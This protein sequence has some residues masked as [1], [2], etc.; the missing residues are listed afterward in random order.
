MRPLLVPVLAL[1][2]AG[3]AHAAIRVSAEQPVASPV[4]APQEPVLYPHTIAS[5][6]QQFLVLWGSGDGAYEGNVGL[7][8]ALV[9]ADG[10]RLLSRFIPGTQNAKNGVIAA[11]WTGAVYVVWFNDV[12]GIS[13]ITFSRDGNLLQPPTVVLRK[14]WSNPGTLAWNGSRALMFYLAG[15]TTSTT[16]PLKG[17]LFNASGSL[18]KAGMSAPELGRQDSFSDLVPHVETDGNGF[19]AVWETATFVPDPRGYNGQRLVQDFHLV[20]LTEN[21]E[22]DGPRV[23]MGRVE[24]NF[25]FSLAFGRGVYAIAVADTGGELVRFI[26]DARTGSVLRL[27]AGASAYLLG[28]LWSG[29]QFVA[30]WPGEKDTLQTL[31]FSGEAEEQAPKAVTVLTFD[32]AVAPLFVMM[33]S[34]GRNVFGAWGRGYNLPFS[35]IYGV[36]FNANATAS[37]TTDPPQVVSIS[38]SRQL[39]PS[40][41]TSGS[42]SLIVWT[43]QS[44]DVYNGRLVGARLSASGAAIDTTPFEIAPSVS[45][46]SGTPA[47]VFT[48]TVYLVAWVDGAYESPTVVKVRSV[49][50]D[51]SLSPPISL[52]GGSFVSAA[53]NGTTTLVVFGASFGSSR[54]AGRR[55]DEI[56]NAIDQTPIG[57]SA[58]G[59]SPRV[60][61]NGSDFFVAWAEGDDF[62]FDPIFPP[63]A[64]L[65]DIFGARVSASG[66]VDAAPLPIAIGPS[67]QVLAGLASD[68]RD[69]LV[70]YV[71]DGNPNDYPPQPF[72]AAKHILREGNL[73]GVTATGDGT[74]VARNIDAAGAYTL[75][76]GGGL[77]GDASGY[78]AAFRQTNGA[79]AIVRTNLRG[80]PG[81]EQVSFVPSSALT[82]AQ[83]PGGPVWIAYARRVDDGAFANTSQVFIRSATVEP[84]IPRSRA[85]RH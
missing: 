62:F 79:P 50:R 57:I 7:N 83:I 32:H 8:V 81:S 48:G 5:D 75:G 52:G 66:A 60:A 17:A 69:Y 70:S 44:T 61:S 28:L 21:G 6:G 39:L 58:D 37:A 77:S 54:I 45:I 43:E 13:T 46:E 82:L 3:P 40:I 23:D 12:P 84:S 20:R 53:T 31:P 42:D 71:D 38:W 34:N 29:S 63:P 47:V 4:P 27:S 26:V 49:S 2:L 19:A 56:G 10:R 68:G 1:V 25:G 80:V 73:D 67:D 14:A 65:F 18:I 64:S 36:L 55:F 78:W 22:I 76:V 51:A 41:A 24:V 74:I 59:T 9:G 35:P 11:F 16:P 85:A 72:L 30:Y 33:A 15:G